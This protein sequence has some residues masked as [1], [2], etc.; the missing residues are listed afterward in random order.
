MI[1]GSDPASRTI[2]LT[3]LE[4]SHPHGYG[5]GIVLF[6]GSSIAVEEMTVPD[7]KTID[8]DKAIGEILERLQERFPA[9]TRDAVAAAVDQARKSFDD[10]KV[11]DFVP[12]LIEKE[13]KAILKGKR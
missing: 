3:C 8:E 9:K 6:D 10:A 11:R 1:G 4:S 2:A 5:V 12:V 7:D 13:A